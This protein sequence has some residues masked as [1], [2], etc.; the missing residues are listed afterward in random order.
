MPLLTMPPRHCAE[1][2]HH[3]QPG[4]PFCSPCRASPGPGMPPTPALTPLCAAVPAMSPKP[5]SVIP[6]P[7]PLSC[8]A[9]TFS[10]KSAWMLRLCPPR[11]LSREGAG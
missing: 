3:Q 6:L 8:T 9:L 1:H 5:F 4:V 7:A 10:E 11:S 2:Q